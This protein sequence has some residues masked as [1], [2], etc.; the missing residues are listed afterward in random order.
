MNLTEKILAAHSGRRTVVPGE[1]I[2]AKI[3]LIL[4]NEL[5]T[6][7][8]IE[9]FRKTGAKR[10]VNPD[11]IVLVLDHFTPNKDIRTAEICKEIRAFARE[12]RIRH[13]F[14]LG[15]GGIEH[16]ILPE[17][18][19]VRPGELI[20]G[21]DSHTTTYGA[22]GAFATGVGSS[23]V[24]AGFALGEIWLRVPESMKITISGSPKPWVT[25]KD[26]I[27]C[28]IS[29][30]GTDGALYKAVEFA[31]ETIGK[32]GMSDRFTMTNMALEMGAKNALMPVDGIAV[33]YLRSVTGKAMHGPVVKDPAWKYSFEFD[34]SGM[35]PLVALPPSPANCLPVRD[36]GMVKLDQVLIGS[37]T[38]GRLEDLRLAAGVLK[39]RKAHPSLRLIVA[40][41]S[42]KIY[43]EAVNE[44]LISTFVASGAVISPPTCGACVGGHM[45]LLA[46]GERCLSTTNRNF[47]GRMGHPKSEIYLCNPAVAAASAVAGRIVHPEDVV[48]KKRAACR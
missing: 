7:L 34:V 6:I 40:P 48:G 3:D 23:D 38:N 15:N 14:E 12:N 28:V 43:A 44:G 47:V 32:L 21:G 8:A 5:S 37:C 17:K 31:G 11:G 13:V 20:I 46:E 41:G 35:E 19:F 45:G 30:L 27:L 39:G 16:I 18:G 33:E 42:Q 4:G 36:A 25:G 29:K 24:A 22:L 9:E 10:V 1:I 26:L 2:N